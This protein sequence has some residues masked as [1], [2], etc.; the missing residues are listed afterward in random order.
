MA[1]SCVRQIR[2]NPSRI[3][4]GPSRGGSC[5]RRTGRADQDFGRDAE[6]IMQASDH[7]EAEAALAVQD[8][9]HPSPRSDVWLDRDRQCIPAAYESAIV[10][11]FHY[12]IMLPP[13]ATAAIMPPQFTALITS[14]KFECTAVDFLP[15]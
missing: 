8:L 9:S 5:R 6:P 13:G 14:L 1:G 7:N 12:F 15:D 11:I 3:F 2:R 4:S 10:L